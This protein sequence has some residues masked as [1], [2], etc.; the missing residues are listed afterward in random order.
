[1]NILETIILY[2]Q[3]E[4][5][6]QKNKISVEKLLSSQNFKRKSLS[7]IQNLKKQD[8]SGIIAEFK[9]K[10]PSKGFIN[11][12]ADAL[13]ITNAYTKGGA[14][15]LSILT[16]T[17]F[18]G[19]S[20][21]DLITARE[22]NIPILRKDFI[23]DMYQIAEAKAMGADAIL[24]IAACLTPLQ[25]QILAQYAVS[26]GLEVLLELHEDAELNHICNETILIG[27][28]NRNLKTFEVDTAAALN[29]ASK[30]PSTK[31]KVAESGISNLKILQQFK[32]AG[33]KGFL[34]G[35]LFMKAT[36]PAVAF[37][38]FVNKIKEL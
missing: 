13:E 37:N 15:G 11:E 17:H 7:L 3:E 19:G 27:V 10:S 4:V 8:S 6:K 35:E 34:I 18:F 36:I 24:L 1:M 25:V 29:L 12:H 31:I 30:I 38:N 33:F 14:A 32:N 22:N 23:I 2:K 16:D 28:N 9:R 21:A 5:K 26:I 20:T